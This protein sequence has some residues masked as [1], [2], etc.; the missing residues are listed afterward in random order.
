MRTGSPPIDMQLGTVE[1]F[2][3]RL[4]DLG[5]TCLSVDRAGLTDAITAASTAPAVASRAL[6]TDAW[7]SDTWVTVD[8]TPEEVWN[9]STG[10]TR[11]ALGISPYGSV[12][13]PHDDHGS[14]FISLFVDKHVA[15]IDEVDIVTDMETAVER[16][17]T[18]AIDHR[19]SGIIAT[20]PSA[21]ADMGELVRGAHGPESV[22]V[23]VVKEEDP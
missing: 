14:E 23:I 17:A 12:Y 18:G 7:L 20:G 11:A 3:T 6:A 15:V 4:E 19:E 13:L 5:A 22:T 8:P 9:A 10:I 16:L 21:T 1:T 2:R